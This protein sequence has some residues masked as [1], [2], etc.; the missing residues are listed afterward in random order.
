[1]SEL[2][3]LRSLPAGLAA[4]TDEARARA[5][6][7]LLRHVRRSRFAQRRR[8]LV[9]AVALAGAV[10]VAALVGV[11]LRGNGNAAAAVALRHAAAAARVQPAPK[12]LAPGQF[13]YTRSIQAYTSAGKNPHD[14]KPWTALGPRVRETWF[15]RKTGMIREVSR[16]PVFLSAADRANWIAAGRPEV[17]PRVATD[18]VKPPPPLDLPSD[19]DRLYNTIHDRAVGHGSGTNSETFVLVGDALRENY[20]SPAVRAALYEVAARIP[21][22]ELVGPATDRIGRHGI[23]VAYADSSNHQ[24]HQLI[25]DPRTAAL[26]EEDYVELKGS[27][28]GYPPGTITGYATYVASGPVDRLGA[29]PRK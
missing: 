4:P 11:S 21:G 7:R 26:L 16:K 8:L 29:R 24:R 27:Y 19:P 12:P 5:R 2:E 15:G 25:F 3:L 18:L 22:V 28:Y 13:W 14:G 10:A 1:M 9:P 17:N 23:A 20:L 6:G